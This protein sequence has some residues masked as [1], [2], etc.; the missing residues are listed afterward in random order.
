MKEL[1]IS[2]MYRLFGKDESH[3]CKECSNLFKKTY[4]RSYYKCDVYGSSSSVAT[5]WRCGWTACG[6]FNRE[7]D[8]YKIKDYKKHEPRG[9]PDEEQLHGQMT[10]Y[11]LDMKNEK[12]EEFT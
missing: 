5:D 7:W 4:S 3:K 2:T 12:V 6:M 9:N 11:D 10:I 1:I 8:G